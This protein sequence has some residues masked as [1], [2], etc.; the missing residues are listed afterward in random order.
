MKQPLKLVRFATNIKKKNLLLQYQDEQNQMN[1]ALLGW[2][3]RLPESASQYAQQ[4]LSI[5]YSKNKKSL[6]GIAKKFVE[7]YKD[8]SFVI[9][10][11]E[12]KNVFGCISKELIKVDTPE[13]NSV[14]ELHKFL[15]FVEMLANDLWVK[16]DSY[17]RI[18]I[19]GD[20]ECIVTE[21]KR[22]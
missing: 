1:L 3:T 14:E 8:H 2:L 12:A 22:N 20:A 21:Y 15:S 6:E 13:I 9:D 18:T 7:H 11:E 10:Y 5:N 19:I 17:I 4:L 16:T